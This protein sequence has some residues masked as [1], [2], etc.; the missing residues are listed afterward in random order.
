MLCFKFGVALLL[1]ED[2]YSDATVVYPDP[3][4][5][6]ILSISRCT[7][8]YCCENC[9]HEYYTP[10]LFDGLCRNDGYRSDT[11]EC[12]SGR[13]LEYHKWSNIG[14]IGQPYLS[15]HS[16]HCYEDND[17]GGSKY[18]TCSYH[19]VGSQEKEEDHEWQMYFIGALIGLMILLC[20]LF[21]GYVVYKRKVYR[22]ETDL[23]ESYS[24][25]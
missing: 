12:T 9:Q 11:Y 6:G 10:V 4:R 13:Y 20:G 15:F 23:L 25:L 21:G 2:T 7:D 17:N 22:K 16:G 14:C 19:T 3:L 8:K 1:F 24:N 18:F 5:R